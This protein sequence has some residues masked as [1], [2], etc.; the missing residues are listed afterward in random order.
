MATVHGPPAKDLRLKS[1]AIGF[2]VTL[3]TIAALAGV[4]FL[5]APHTVTV[6]GQMDPEIDTWAVAQ[7][8]WQLGEFYALVI[9]MLAIYWLLVTAAGRGQLLRI[10][11]ANVTLA[12]S[13]LIFAL[14]MAVATFVQVPEAFKAACPV[15]GVSDT[16]PPLPEG[17]F[18]FDGQTP[19]E[20][21]LRRA[22]PSCLFGLPTIMLIASA[23]LRIFGSR[24]QR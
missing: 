11:S 2:G 7:L 15:L 4:Q 24:T 5:L 19:C 10:R 13:G 14:A 20:T 17:V 16:F 1:A 22:V 3:A 12:F 6:V 23:V 8:R 18:R 21:F 9:A